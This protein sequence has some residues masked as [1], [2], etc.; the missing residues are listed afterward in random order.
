M[1]KQDEKIEVEID[2]AEVTQFEVDI[3]EGTEHP[4]QVRETAMIWLLGNIGLLVLFAAA[5]IGAALPV[6]TETL[7]GSIVTAVCMM[8]LA[9]G[10]VSQLLS[11][12]LQGRS[13]KRILTGEW[14]ET[15]S[16]AAEHAI[17]WNYKNR[18]SKTSLIFAV[19]YPLVAIIA[20]RIGIGI[21]NEY[22]M[23]NMSI[24]VGALVFAYVSKSIDLF[25]L[26]K[27]EKLGSW[28][29]LLIIRIAT[30][31]AI[32]AFSFMPGEEWNPLVAF[33]GG[34]GYHILNFFFS[35]GISL[36]IA[37]TRLENRYLES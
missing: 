6:L 17:A 30:V 32:M 34:V 28:I 15:F 13:I 33:L 18:L 29:A 35:A 1:P 4:L 11:L 7:F 2:P 12:V 23:M 14:G 37:K 10:V 5:I 20:I 19:L 27:R 8:I 26:F 9:F 22:G 21:S 31:A 36:V 16:D 24:I 25:W 3:P